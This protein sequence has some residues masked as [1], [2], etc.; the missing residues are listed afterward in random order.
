MRKSS[1]RHPNA[2]RHG[3]YAE[4]AFLPGEDPE[5][6]T[7]S[8]SRLI[9]E[10]KPVGLTEEDAVLAV[11]TGMWRKRRVQKFLAAKIMKCWCD[12]EHDAYD[13]VEPLSGFRKL[14]KLAPDLVRQSLSY[15]GPDTRKY[16]LDKFPLQRSAPTPELIEVVDKEITSHIQSRQRFG[17]QV[18]V[19]S[20]LILS[21]HDL[22]YELQLTSALRP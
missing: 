1:R 8:Y 3:M 10:W 22:I 18:P 2:L 9:D 13:E 6:F 21:E 5:E 17:P 4:P 20:P 7:K 19:D 14:M 15:L 16:L 12:P 11:A